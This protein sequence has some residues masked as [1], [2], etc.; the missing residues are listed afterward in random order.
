MYNGERRYLERRAE[1]E[2]ALALR[3]QHP[4]AVKA[5]YEMLGRYL[6]RLYP[7]EG[8]PVGYR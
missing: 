1:D 5:H 3:A 2:L 7:E 4:A 8:R 6:N